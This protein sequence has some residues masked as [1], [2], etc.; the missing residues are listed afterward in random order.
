MKVSLNWLREFTELPSSVPALVDLLTLAGVE[1][2]SVRQL[3]VDLPHVVVAEIRESV[4][5]P[6]A[7]RLSVCQVD[8]GSGVP[9]QIVCGAKNYQ[10]GDKVPLALP[11]AVLPGDFKIKVG[12]LRGVESQGMLCSGEELGLP[13]GEDGLLILPSEARPGSP[14]GELFQPDTILDLE[15]TPNRPDLL[16][17]FGIA[18]EIAVLTGRPTPAG[19]QWPDIHAT[20]ECPFSV[21]IQTSSPT[22][23]SAGL[24]SGVTIAPS[25][26]WLKA[27]LE[28]VGIRTINN[29]VDLTNYLLMLSGQPTHVLDAD[30]VEGTLCV[31]DALAGEQFVA[32]NGQTYLLTPE[33][34][35]IADDRKVLALAGVIGGQESSVTFRSKNVILEIANFEPARIRRTSRRLGISTD[36]SYRFEREVDL[37]LT[38][39]LT[40]LA[41]K[42]LAELTQAACLH[43]S[44]IQSTNPGAERFLHNE[45]RVVPLRKDRAEAI[46]G[47]SLSDERI[48]QIL[49]GFGLSQ[50]PEGWTIPT[51]RS[52]LTREIDLIEELARVV[53]LDAIPSRVQAQFAPA[54]ASDRGYDRAMALRRSCAA[55]GLHE[56]RSVSLVPAEPL[57]MAALQ[58]PPGDLLRVK[59][60][61]IDDQ[62]VLRP[63]LLH[64][65]FKAVGHNIR[66][67]EKSVRLFEIGR[68]YSRN[69]PEE[70]SHLAVVL[71]GP[72]RRRSWR[73]GEGNDADL[74]ELKGLLG[75][76]L[77]PEAE[78]VPRQNAAIALSLELQIRGQTIGFAG[79]LWPKDARELDSLGPVLFAEIDLSQ[80]AAAEGKAGKYREIP[81]FPASS[82]D[83]ALLAPLDLP[84]GR[85]TRVLAEAKEPLLA[86]AE[87]FD[88]FTD[89]TGAKVPADKKS[90]AY[91]LTYRS[92]ERTLTADEINAAHAKLKERLKSELNVALRE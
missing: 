68:V 36:A 62:V 27:K 86:G 90:L 80:L 40:G 89:A 42:L 71:S 57:G 29:A 83:I 6:N 47:I 12:K 13:K 41:G 18:R 8:D 32:L 35:V 65:L 23:Y 24:A 81:R 92:A 84:H 20:G 2:E 73:E 55:L 45:W 25:P 1:V 11:G 17:H 58:I 7:D 15:I 64:G 10:V 51:W 26:A 33:D 56:A 9:R 44:S 31:R 78:F 19:F 76:L 67:G 60:P 61:M 72:L 50:K 28:A 91:S 39:I 49:Q 74:F 53:G 43:R 48:S 5:H 79:Q 4:Q 59:N 37:G 87:L 63:H 82:R 52:D 69:V 14:I 66:S 21:G 46:L 34:L 30:R 16:S 85:I 77:G 75:A 88:V 38:V 22:Y 70:K 54:S 3:G